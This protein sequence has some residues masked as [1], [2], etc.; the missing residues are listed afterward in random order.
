M[1]TFRNTNHNSTDSVSVL[2][3]DIFLKGSTR[4]NFRIVKNP[5]EQV[6]VGK[7]NL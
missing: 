5:T 3:R 4:D 1:K 2:D 7:K 6:Q